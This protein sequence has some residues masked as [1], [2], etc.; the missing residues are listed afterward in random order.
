M[1]SSFVARVRSAAPAADVR[2]RARAARSGRADVIQIEELHPGQRVRARR[3]ARAR[4]AAHAGDLRQAGSARRPVLR[5]DDLRDAVARS[6]TRMQQRIAT[7]SRTRPRRLGSTTVRSTPSAASTRA[8]SSCWRV[9]ARPIGGLCARALTLRR[10]GRQ[11]V[12]GLE[13]LLLRHAL[14]EQ[15]RRVAS[16]ADASGVMM[17]P[18]PRGGVYRRVDGVDAARP[19]PARRG[20]C[21]SRRSRTS[22]SCRCRRARATWDSSSRGQAPAEVERAVREAHAR[23]RSRS[24]VGSNEPSSAAQIRLQWRVARL[25]LAIVYFVCCGT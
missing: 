22:S 17:I 3:R 4:R 5:G 11:S 6:A 16:R 10:A 8:A 18:I 2:R 14:G 21:R 7:R 1:R 23:L 19:S 12:P 9:A 24:T 15:R 13:E 20:D 25:R